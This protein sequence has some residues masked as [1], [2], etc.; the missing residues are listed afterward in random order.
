MVASYRILCLLV[1][2][3]NWQHLTTPDK[4]SDII[5]TVPQDNQ[6]NKII[7]Q[8]HTFVTDESLRM[9]G[10]LGWVREDFQVFQ[11]PCARYKKLFMLKLRVRE[12]V[13]LQVERKLAV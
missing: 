4:V 1:M 10:L 12:Y 9:F 3:L 8:L 13:F 6:G 11:Q 2:T 7:P 5:D